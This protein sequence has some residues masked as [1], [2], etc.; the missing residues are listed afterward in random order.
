MTEQNYEILFNKAASYCSLSERCIS[1]IKEKLT[2]WGANNSQIKNIVAYL[3]AEKYIDQQRFASAYTRDKLRFNHWGKVKIGFML[4]SKGIDN[5]TI[6]VV[7]KNIDTEEYQRILYNL[8][9]TKIKNI[10]AVSDYEK[11]GK[12]MRFLQGK[13]FEFAEIECAISAIL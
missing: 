7:L 12:L 4:R 5:E 13:G 9:K 6:T 2:I 11:R 3:L 8:L 1:E 10:K